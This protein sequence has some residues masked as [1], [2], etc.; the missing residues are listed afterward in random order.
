MILNPLLMVVLRLLVAVEM[1]RER[2]LGRV[3]SDGEWISWLLPPTSVDLLPVSSLACYH[4]DQDLMTS[5]R[6]PDIGDTE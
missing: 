4:K 6:L 1:L 2:T 3:V 5:P